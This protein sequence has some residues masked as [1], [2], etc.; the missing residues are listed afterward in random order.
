M[1]H[2]TSRRK[3]LIAGAAI[4][5]SMSTRLFAAD[6]WPSRPIRILVGFPAGG[7]TDVIARAFGSFLA[8]ELGQ[9]VVVENKAGAGGTLAA[10]ELKRSAADGHT[11]MYA[12]GTT[13]ILNRLY[14]KNLGYD[15][16]KDFSILSMIPGGGAPLVAASKLNVG[17][18]AEFVAYA[19]KTEKVN[20]GT[21]APGSFAH[22]LIEQLNTQFGLKLEP[23]HYRGEAPMWSDLAGGSIDAAIGS[24][25]AAASVIESGRAKAIA[26]SRSRIG[27]LPD[28]KTFREQ[29]TT[30]RAFDLL[31][32]QSC[33]ASSATPTEIKTRLAG[34]LLEASKSDRVKELL[35][36]FGIEEPAMGME[37]A[38]KLYFDELPVWLDSASGLEVIP[39]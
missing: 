29:G 2:K 20:V 34:L 14:N 36:T 28:V 37:A 33:V 11:L 30:S 16:D 27:K 10:Q 24:Y 6:P 18:L 17:N 1:A 9:P 39:Q 25:T 38:Q 32:F 8:K 35:A 13:L 26:I 4:F 12:I 22:M 23:V 15:A 5:G 21:Y 7:Q 3:L 19:R 31:T